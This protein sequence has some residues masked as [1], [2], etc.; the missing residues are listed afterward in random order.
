MKKKATNIFKFVLL[1]LIF[2]YMTIYVSDRNGYFSYSNYRKSEITEEGIKRFES[3][4][5]EGKAI[6]VESYIEKEK[7]YSNSISRLS[8]DIS[9]RLGNLIRKGIVGLFDG[10]TSNIE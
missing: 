9:N 8:L 1:T 4:I 2:I 6:D 5:K 7:D 10:I 3:D